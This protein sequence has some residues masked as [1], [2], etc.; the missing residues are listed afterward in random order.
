MEPE[1]TDSPASALEH[2][3]FIMHD[4]VSANEALRGWRKDPGSSR[5][6]SCFGQ[7]SRTTTLFFEPETTAFCYLHSMP[8]TLG[9]V[10]AWTGSRLPLKYDDTYDDRVREDPS[11]VCL[12]DAMLWASAQKYFLKSFQR[13]ILALTMQSLLQGSALPSL[14]IF[15]KPINTQLHISMRTRQMSTM[16]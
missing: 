15:A 7:L 1:S 10:H 14:D 2:A 16:G 6:F 9:S 11:A 13:P 3:K 8:K 12:E 5:H 4:D